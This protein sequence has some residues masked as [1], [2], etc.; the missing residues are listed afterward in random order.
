MLKRRVAICLL[1]NDGVLFRTKKFQPDYRYTTAFVGVDAVDEVFLID[2]TRSG[3][4]Q[5][6]WDAM[7]GYA[8]RCYAPVTMGGHIKTLDDVKRFFDLGADKVVCERAWRSVNTPKLI[9]DVAVKWG[10]QAFVAGVTDYGLNGDV[11][12]EVR[13]HHWAKHA[14]EHGAGEIFLQSKALDGSLSGYDIQTV[15]EVAGNVKIPVVVGTSCGNV[16]HMRAAFE[17][18]ASGCATANIHH[19]TENAIRGFKAQLREYVR[20]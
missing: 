9:S 6:S 19:F 4:S 14:E 1:F 20:P 13:P 15:K 5:A 10:A 11:L 7:K 2:I 12:D 3:P 8:D 18:G 16:G 17:A